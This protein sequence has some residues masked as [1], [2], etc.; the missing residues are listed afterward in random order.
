MIEAI[1]DFAI[2]REVYGMDAKK[3]RIYTQSGSYDGNAARQFNIVPEITREEEIIRRERPRQ[4][5]KAKPRRNPAINFLT[6]LTLL[7]AIGVT[8]FSAVNYLKVQTQITDL[9][10]SVSAKEI[11]LAQLKAD[12]D[13]ALNKINTSLDLKNVFDVAVSEL[14]MVFPNNNKVVTYESAVSEYVRQ[15]DSVPEANAEELLDKLFK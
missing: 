7:V 8:L 4:V 6:F 10:K 3:R 15:Y 14:G 5:P 2:G 12:N 13:A 9:S 1:Y 11:E